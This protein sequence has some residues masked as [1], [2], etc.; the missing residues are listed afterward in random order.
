VPAV[1][2]KGYVM[3]SSISCIMQ[4]LDLFEV[5]YENV[6]TRSCLCTALYICCMCIW[7]IN[8]YIN[9]LQPAVG[10]DFIGE[11]ALWPKTSGIG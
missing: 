6:K 2:V 11:V 7:S 4:Y 5:L 8:L 10:A 9:I 3:N 1:K